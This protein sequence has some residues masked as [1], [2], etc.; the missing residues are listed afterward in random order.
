MEGGKERAVAF[1]FSSRVSVCLSGCMYLIPLSR[2]V[3]ECPPAR[4][5][6]FPEQLAWLAA[7]TM[8]GVCLSAACM[9]GHCVGGH[10]V[11]CLSACLADFLAQLLSLRSIYLCVVR[12]LAY[13]SL[14]L[15]NCRGFLC[16]CVSHRV[17]GRGVV[18]VGRDGW[19]WG[20]E[21]DTHEGDA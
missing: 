15:F 9:C 20:G 3:S 7:L 8:L 13:L 11:V 10:S 4:A 2:L 5:P 18:C 12:P 16:L 1:L 14:C 21:V 19:V 6:C 17:Y